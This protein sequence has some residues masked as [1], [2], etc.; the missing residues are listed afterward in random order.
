MVRS[1]FKAGEFFVEAV[2]R[3]GKSVEDARAE[4]RARGD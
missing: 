2:A 3:D 1:S 4:A